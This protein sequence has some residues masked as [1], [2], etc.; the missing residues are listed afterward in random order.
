MA[1]IVS[2]TPLPLERDSRT[3]KFAA[4]FTRLG[5]RSIVV[6][7]RSSADLPRDGLPFELRS[8]GVP[9]A[10]GEGAGDRPGAGSLGRLAEPPLALAANLR[11]NLRTLRELPPAD[12]YHLHS[13]NQAGAV[14]RRARGAA[15]PYVYDAHDA[16]WEAGHEIDADHRARL[17]RAMF[18]R[19]E[20]RCVSGAALVSTVSAGVA[21]LLERRFGR[22]PVVIRNFQDPRLDR[23]ADGDVRS[24][25]GVGAGA[26]LLVMV[27]NAKPGDAVEEAVRALAELPDRVHLALVGRG[28]G[29]F[30]D[31]ADRSGVGSRVHILDPV[32]PDQVTDF[33]SSADA[34]P[35]LYRAWTENFE[36]ALPNRFSHAVAAGLPVLYPPLT[37]IRALCERHG[38]GL[39]IDPA[40]PRS[41]AGAV[42]LLA[43]DPGRLAEYGARVRAAQPELSWEAEEGRIEEMLAEALDRGAGG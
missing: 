7:G 30:A 26:F 17:T 5:H 11:W 34:S 33:I 21:G 4:S 36:H 31:S 12:L 23:P 40:D 22:S 19:V 13:Y 43:D 15:A 32:A 1:T 39:E 37:E 14:R 2:V 38:L 27:G 28:H 25:A 8:V 29:R 3:F 20:R 41:I 6:E 24:A 42:R 35:I 16:Y 10:T 18:Q 9:G